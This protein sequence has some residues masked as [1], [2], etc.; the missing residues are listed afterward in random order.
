MKTVST[1]LKDDCF[2][3]VEKFAMRQRAADLSRAYSI[4][5]ALHDLIEA[6]LEHDEA[7]QV[8]GTLA[9]GGD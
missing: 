7:N 3:R 6:G 4:A 5:S 9:V 2:K 8:S 1:R